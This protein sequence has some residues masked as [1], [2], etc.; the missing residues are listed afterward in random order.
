VRVRAVAGLVFALLLAACGGADQTDA[1]AAPASPSAAGAASETGSG[2]ASGDLT[3]FAAASLTDAFEELGERFE[4]A[5]P[6]VS[7]AFNFESSSTLAT[8]ITEGAP[9]D[10]FASASQATMDTVDDAGLVAGERTD[11]AGNSLQIAVEPG[12]PK[13]IDGLEDLAQPD[14]TVVLAAEEVPAGEY[15]RQ[16]LDEQGIDVEPASL[17]TD[18]R[19]VLSRVALGEADAGIVY[20]SDVM[21]AGGDVEGV[22]IPADQNVPASYPIAT[23]AEA[24]NPAAGK[25]FV[26]YVLS[27][28][29]QEVLNEFGFSSP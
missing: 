24:P 9:A 19:A 18:V 1:P 8:Q 16:A 6:D 20:V 7:V 2:V 11:F 17:E 21:A 13:G 4:Q 28:E 10:V 15:A 3:V 12:N 23:L 26:A 25:A 14:L 27:G 22:E 29:G 5:N